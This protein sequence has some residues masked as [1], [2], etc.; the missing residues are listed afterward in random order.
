MIFRN[1]D[2]EMDLEVQNNIVINQFKMYQTHAHQMAEWESPAINVIGKSVEEASQILQ[3][4]GFEQVI[5]AD[6]Y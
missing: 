5:D 6:P 1:E 3:S 2:I 4:E